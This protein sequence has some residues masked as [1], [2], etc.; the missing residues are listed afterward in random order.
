MVDARRLVSIDRSRLPRTPT[1]TISGDEST[2]VGGALAVVAGA[3]DASG[4]GAT[5][6][7]AAIAG[8]GVVIDGSGA[9]CGSPRA[10]AGAASITAM[11]LMLASR[12]S[13]T[14]RFIIAP[15]KFRN[16][17]LSRGDAVKSK[18]NET[19]YRD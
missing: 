3:C 17:Y 8:S 10:T 5:A 1:T 14:E 2:G 13:R 18:R 19:Q 4:D 6:S 11:P 15:R 12:T 9:A 7:G 16:S